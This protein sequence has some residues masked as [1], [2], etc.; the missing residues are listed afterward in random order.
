MQIETPAIIMEPIT[1]TFSKKHLTAFYDQLFPLI[2]SEYRNVQEP[3]PWKSVW[4]TWKQK[5]LRAANS[6]RKMSLILL[7][8]YDKTTKVAKLMA[9]MISILNNRIPIIKSSVTF[10]KSDDDPEK[11]QAIFLNKDDPMSNSKPEPSRDELHESELITEQPLTKSSNFEQ[12]EES[13][14]GWTHVPGTHNKTDNDSNINP[15]SPSQNKFALLSE[16]N[17]DDDQLL[18]YDDTVNNEEHEDNEIN[19][20]ITETNN[21]ITAAEIKEAISIIDNNQINQDNLSLITKWIISNTTNIEHNIV[22]KCDTTLQACQNKINDQEEKL[23]NHAN[24]IIDDI[25][26]NIKISTDNIEK[27]SK[28]IKNEHKGT[29]LSYTKEVK[30]I[31]KHLANDASNAMADINNTASINKTE[32]QTLYEQLKG[33]TSKLEASQSVGTASI[34]SINTLILELRRTINDTYAEYEDDVLQIADNEKSEFRTWIDT[35]M[36]KVTEYNDL[37]KSITIEKD[38]CKAERILLENERV[39]QTQWFNEMKQQIKTDHI[40]ISSKIQ[41]DDD[42]LSSI[43]LK[44]T[45]TGEIPSIRA[46]MQPDTLIHYKNET[47]SD[48]TGFIMNEREPTYKNGYWH[49]DIF[50]A[51]GINM[52]DCSEKYMNIVTEKIGQDINHNT[53]QPDIGFDNI[54]RHPSSYTSPLKKQHMRSMVNKLHVKSNPYMPRELQA[55]EFEFPIGSK[56]I[57]V[58]ANDLTKAAAKW[59]LKLRYES[60]LRGSYERLQTR[61]ALFNIYLIDYDIIS[62]DNQCCQ[63]SPSTCKNYTNARKQMGRALFIVLEDNQDQYFEHYTLPKTFISAYRRQHDGFGLITHIME[64]KHPNL[65]ITSNRKAPKEP[66]FDDYSSIYEFIDAYID[67][68][69]D[70]IIRADRKYTDREKI[71]HIRDEL[72]P[73][74]QT[75]KYK[76]KCKLDELDADSEKPF[77]TNLQLNERLA[78]YIVSLLPEGDKANINKIVDYPSLS[79]MD[80]RNGSNYK[81]KPPYDKGKY[82]SPYN[83]RNND[84]KDSQKWADDLK[85]EIIPGAKCPA[86]YKQHNVYTTGCPDLARFAACKEFYDST[87]AAKLKPVLQAYQRYQATQT[88]RMRDRRNSDRR[89]IRTLKSEYDEDDISKIKHSLFHEY[90]EDF[91]EAQYTTENPLDQL[92][93][94]TD[95]DS[96]M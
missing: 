96:D 4:D 81:S 70:E 27:L 8:K 29:I 34:K 79:K 40:N 25:N 76:I 18:S 20:E 37:L 64:P 61:L 71:D 86:C 2:D 57:T 46:P 10:T 77:P 62:K 89:T 3:Q 50:T 13:S 92:D 72:S 1:I 73:A 15:D 32:L 85:W 26:N 65:R 7:G 69:D 31:R 36:T 58:Y 43:A 28:D 21:T 66:A 78:K 94:E 42:T 51:K 5:G 82:Q 22:T 55:D 12:V 17:D 48:V 59:D 91:K 41:Q 30:S 90:K 9:T 44:P 35:R 38:L 95:S 47:T 24:I 52:R 39:T 33:L 53:D 49:Y 75:A 14:I 23:N 16:T 93:E 80:N 74:F 60:D 67:W 11:W 88:K 19:A 63:I 56:P 54:T 83:K 6:R 84:S 45:P 87:P 68:C